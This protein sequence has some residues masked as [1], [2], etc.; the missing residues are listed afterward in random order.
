MPGDEID[1]GSATIR[2]ELDDVEAVS[3][4]RD[5]GLRIRRALDRAT[6]DTGDLIRRNIERGM[7]AAAVAVTVEPDLR[8]FES[9]LLT[10]LRGLGSISIPVE[11]DLTGFT[12]RLRAHL[13][14]E[15]LRVQV[16][17]DL[18]RFDSGLLTGLRSL[19]SI[20]V[21]VTPDLTGFVERIRA[22]LAGEE[23]AVR[24]VP[25]MDG[26]DDRIRAHN[27]PDVTVDVNADV[28]SNRFTR[29]LS[30]LGRIAGRVGS[31]LT[32]LLQFGAVGIAAAGA[33]QGVIGLTAALA[34]AAGIIAALPAAVAGFQAAL[35]TLR[36]A[37]V[38]VGDALG[39]AFAGDAAKFQEA[40]EKLSPSA[41]KAVL[42]VKEFAPELK[43]VQQSVQE[44]FFSQFAGEI[45]GAVK[46]LLPMQSGLRA[47]ALGF[48]QAAQE[49]LKFLQTRQALASVMGVLAGTSDAVEG[50]SAA[51]GPLAQGLLSVASSVSQAFGAR[52][53]TALGGLGQQL[54][55][56]LTRIANNG[57][58]VAWVEGALTVF[59]QLGSIISN[60]GQILSGV[61]QAANASG[62]GL[63]N[64][65]KQITASFAEFVNSAQGQEAIG[66]IFSTLATVAAQLG[67]ILSA[68]VTQVGAIAPALA[69]IFTALGPAI[70]N[71]VN[72]LG[73]ALAAIAPALA[74]VGQALA[75]GLGALGPSLAPL[76]EA[77]GR[78]VTALAPLLPLVGEVAGAVAQ[79]LA[80][81]LD[82]LTSV[83][84]P[85]IDALV[86]ALLPIL[87]Q[88][89]TAF[90]TLGAALGPVAD[91][92]GKSLGDALTR[93]LPPILELIPQIQG[94]MVPAW[95]ALAEAVTP[96]IPE[97]VNLV[98]LAIEPLL[99]MLPQLVDMIADLSA[100]F[101]LALAAV[102][103]I[104]PPLVRLFT[105][106]SQFI[107]SK[108]TFPL[109]QG[110][111]DVLGLLVGAVTT[112]QTAARNFFTGTI[113]FFVDLGSGIL[114]ALTSL[115]ERIAT[116]FTGLWTTVS[117]AVVTG[118]NAVVTFFA[119]LPGLILSALAALPGLLI[120]FFVNAIAGLGIAIL[121]GI[122][123]VIFV[124]TE[125]PGMIVSAL[126]SLG[127][128]LLTFFTT[129]F[130]TVVAAVTSFISQVVAFFAALPGQI[131]S[132]LASLPGRVVSFFRSA[133][134]SALSTARSYGT[135]VINFFRELPGRIASG[136][137]SLG[138]KLAEKLQSAG[139]A[140]LRGAQQLISTIANAF[141]KLPGLILGKIGDIGS[142]I[143][144]KIAGGLPASVRG[145][146]PGLANGGIVTGPTFA[147]LGEGSRPEVVIPLTKPKRARELAAKSGLLNLLA[148]PAQ[149]A[150]LAASSVP[151][152]RG[153][154]SVKDFENVGRQ[155]GAGLVAGLRAS[156]GD[157]DQTTQ[158]LVGIAITTAEKVLEIASP[159]K[160]FAR[161]GKDTGRGFIVG[162]TGTADQIKATTDKLIKSITDAF[163]GKATKVDDRLVTLLQSGNKKLTS[164]AAQRDALVKKIADAQKFAADTT[165]SVLQAFSLQSLTQGGGKLTADSIVAGLDGALSKVR[166]F[167]SQINALA[168]RG[169]RKDLLQQIIGLGP[170]QGAE[171]ARV[172]STTDKA[173]FKRIN[174]MQAQLVSASNVLGRT[175]AD[176]LFDAGKNA[177]AGFLAGLQGQRKAIE[178]LMVDIAKSMQKA[179][180][181][182]LRI[183]SPS[184]VFRKIGEMTGLGLRLGLV[185]QI[186]ALQKASTSA[187]RAVVDAVGGQF[188]ALPGRVGSPLDGLGTG[189]VIP[190]T[191]AQKR[192]QVATEISAAELARGRAAVDKAG[193]VFNNTFNITEVGDAGATAQRV[194][195]RLTY[196]AGVS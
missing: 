154:G 26:F 113:Q 165:A 133:G 150:T 49:G 159:S 180:R 87:P 116:F 75:Q 88:I 143:R 170:E 108:T 86:A 68:V 52:L 1:Y 72:A 92:L 152:V 41:Q 42:A 130:T 160:V 184:V 186:A 33:A 131:A 107:A 81:A 34:P 14:G 127:S 111:V 23:F 110:L 24:V 168:R 2:I 96:L 61:F 74:T 73:P 149:A 9:A 71:L 13:A 190:L 21:P 103:P 104:L 171:L 148:G 169:L 53:G 175:G 94:K 50:L 93:L 122:A 67:P 51:V 151:A 189:N 20:N 95:I 134:S 80:P 161:I 183:K 16:V 119:Q 44:A 55:D 90:T 106:V 158:D 76:G 136:L 109:L 118:F 196:A 19:D 100:N 11:P 43:K 174:S 167:T 188:D 138:S 163:K 38:G 147:M 114:D 58:A 173:T 57:Q 137:S 25:D 140:A 102:V 3:D 155:I 36:L 98:V 185:G 144:Q 84:S 178:K 85:I 129:A 146:I 115:P 123:A 91:V 47:I 39:A 30:G 153:G 22:L 120:S 5:L 79:I 15:E 31:G 4:A 176:V 105:T 194:L 28:D 187:A 117:T 89:A 139:S 65:L 29:A 101:V 45:S 164:L 182:A 145:L 124:F 83:L 179:I 37:V 157:V 195:N 64:N 181:T 46:N 10:G 112:A 77:I 63:L 177:G 97:L 66:N 32:S 48:G 69:P 27:P 40:L 125:L 192:R 59:K 166:S 56:F 62:G 191:R 8:R 7:R 142:Q 6:R 18:A 172:L 121:T 126:A 54:G 128:T 193:T 35:G 99:P 162:L 70:V 12:E 60:V 82:I 17:P 135:Q 132:F 141:T 156:L 78:A